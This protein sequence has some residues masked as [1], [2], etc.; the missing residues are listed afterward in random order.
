M[1]LLAVP[2]VA[3]VTLDAGIVR[4][5]A[6]TRA[7][8]AAD[9]VVLFGPIEFESQA[10][11][12]TQYYVETFPDPT[13]PESAVLTITADATV[14]LSA[15]TVRLNGDTLIVA[16][17]LQC[18][19]IVCLPNLLPEIFPPDSVLQAGVTYAARTGFIPLQALNTIEVE[20]D[21]SA[22]FTLTIAVHRPSTGQVTVYGPETFIRSGSPS[23]VADSFSVPAGL[24]PPHELQVDNG[25]P[26]GSAKA[27]SARLWL[28]GDEI[29]TGNDFSQQVD[30]LLRT[31]T[32]LPDNELEVRVVN[33]NG[34]QIT[35]RF[36][37][38]D[39]TPPVLTVTS[40][41][42]SA[43][44]ATDSVLVAGSVSDFTPVV[45]RANGHGAVVDTLGDWS[46]WIPLPTEGANPILVEATDL[47]GLSSSESLTVIRNTAPP[48]LVVSEPE[49]GL[50]TSS[51]SVTVA[52]T[53]T[54]VSVEVN[55][56]PLSL[57]GGA[58]SGEIAL[59]DGPNNLVIT[60]EAAGGAQTNEV[61]SVTRDTVPPMLTVTA[62]LD[63]SSTEDDSVAVAGTV[64]DATDVTVT[65]NGV[66]LPVAG[67]DSF[68]GN[69]A[70]EDGANTILVV[71]TDGAG[72]ESSDSRSVT[73][74]TEPVEPPPDPATVAPPIDPTVPTTVMAATEFLYT[75]PDPIQ[76][77]VEPGTIELKRATVVRG[78][79]L[80]QT[81]VALPGA[82]VSVKD[83]PEFGQTL[84][85]L[86]GGY[87][88]VVNGG[89]P[90]TV[91]YDLSGYL[92]A[93]RT[94]DV[95]WQDWLVLE[96]VALV[97]QDTA[98]TTIDFTDPIEVARG[99]PQTDA[100]GTRQATVLFPQGTTAQM[101]MA[102]GSTQ[103]LSTL[104][105]RL[106]EVTVGEIGPMT[107]PAR[108]PPTSGYT[109]AVNLQADEA[110]A[111]G[112]IGV[113]F[114]QPV[115]LYV[116]NFLGFPVGL[117]VPVGYYD[118]QA[119]AWMPEANGR[120]IEIVGVTGGLADIDTDG[121]GSANAQASLDSLGITANEQGELASLYSIG[122]TLWRMPLTHF[123]PFDGNWQR[124]SDGQTPDGK[125]RKGGGDPN[126]GGGDKGDGSD[127]NEDDP[128]CTRGSII[129]CENQVL[130]ER[131]PIVGT[132][133][134]LNYR[135][136]RVPGNRSNYRLGI[137]VTGDSVPDDLVKAIV[138]VTVAGRVFA[139][140][141]ETLTANEAMQFEWDGLDAY[142][143]PLSASPVSVT[144]SHFYRFY[145]A[146]PASTA[147]SFGLT[148][149][150]AQPGNYLADC[151]I[152]ATLNTE[153][154]QTERFDLDW[155]GYLGI[156]SWEAAGLGG[157]SLSAYHQYDPFSRT[158]YRGDGRQRT[159]SNVDAGVRTIAGNGK[160]GF[161]FGNCHG[162]VTNGGVA[163]EQALCTP[164]DVAVD[165]D[166]SFY[167]PH[168]SVVWK[169]DTA[170]IISRFAG[171]GGS[172]GYS[173]DGG[174]ATSA[175]MQN[176]RA[177]AL[178]PDGSLYIGD[179][180]NGV[181]RRVDPDGTISTFAGPGT[182]EFAEGLPATQTVVGSVTGIDV[183]ED[184]TVYL[185][186]TALGRVL[187]VDPEG[188]VYSIAGTGTPG[189]NGDSIPAHLAQVGSGVGGIGVGPDGAIY[190]ADRNNDR[191]RKIDL[192]GIITTVAGNGQGGSSLVDGVPATQS[193]VDGPTDVAFGPDGSLYITELFNDRLRRVT[194]DGIIT[195]VAGVAQ[196]CLAVVEGTP[197]TSSSLCQPNAVEVFNNEIYIVDWEGGRVRLLSPYA[198]G[199][200]TGDQRIASGDGSEAYVFG[201]LR[202]TETRSTLNG[203]LLNAFANDS[204]GRL[205]SLTNADGLVT[206]IERNG[207]GEPTAI[208]APFGQRTELTVDSL[209]WLSSITNP[210]GEVITVTHDSLGLLESM[211]DPR[212]FEYT[213]AYDSIGRLERDDDPA[214]GFQ[215][216]ARLETEGGHI[217]TR[218]TA[219]G[220]T[221]E[222]GTERLATSER[223][224]TVIGPDGHATSRSILRSGKT[225]MSLPDS[226]T[227]ETV[228]RPDPRFGMQA[229]QLDTL[230]VKTAAGK[231][232][233]VTTESH[234]TASDP[235][236]PLVLDARV[237]TLRLN[238]RVWEIAFDGTTREV[239][240]TS[241]MG[242][243]YTQQLDTLNRVTQ[244]SVPG[245]NDLDIAYDSAGFVSS[246]STGG[247]TWQYRYDGFGRLRAIEDP[248]ARADSFVF[249]AG[250]RLTRTILA[251]GDSVG[252]AYDSASNLTGLTPP[253][254]P[255]HTFSY[256]PVD[257]LGSYV[258]PGA[259]TTAYGNTLDRELGTVIRPGGD[260]IAVAYDTAGRPETL[261]FDGGQIGYSYEAQT[262]Q[263][264]G[265]SGPYGDGLSFG[266]DSFLL[267]DITWSGAVAGSYSVTYEDDFRVTEA[268]V[269]GVNP[270]SFGYDLDGL[271]TSA[272]TL[273]ID[274]DSAN[275]FVTGSTIGSVTTSQ[276][277]SG[278]G[279]LASFAAAYSGSGLFE[280][281]YA[282]DA[283]GR[284]DTLTQIIQ[285]DTTVFVYG[286]DE[287][288]RL[289]SV[290]TN[291]ALSATYTYD[292]NGNRLQVAG[293][294]GS[295]TGSYDDRDRLLSYG[296]ATYAYAPAGELAEKV[297]GSDTTRYAY[298]ALGNLTSIE[299]PNGTT[300][301]YEVDAAGRRIGRRVNGT[302]GQGFLY[303]DQ[304]SPVA[305][306]DGSGQVVSR[307]VYGDRINVPEY[308]IKGGTTYRI[309]A[310]HLGSVRLVVD[311]ATGAIAQRIYYDEFGVV[312]LNTNPSFQPFGFAGGITDEVTGF[313]R[314]GARDYDPDTGRWTTLD[315]LGIRGNDS[316]AYLYAYGNPVGH[317]DPTGEFVPLVV[318]IPTVGGLV[319]GF[320]TAAG[321][322]ARCGFS[323]GGTAKAFGRGF[324][325]GF[326]G[327]VVGLATTAFTEN[328]IAG[329][330]AAGWAADFVDQVLSGGPYDPRQGI[331]AGAVGGIAGGATHLWGPQ[332]K[333]GSF[334]P[335]LE[336][337][338]RLSEYGPNSRKLLA[339]EAAAGAVAGGGGFGIQAAG[340]GGCGC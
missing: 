314:F 145:Y 29:L 53:T 190:L 166:G 300:I 210:A 11:G 139:D 48:E 109:Y 62:P 103:P 194:P 309:V 94:V 282:R 235:E 293:P 267:T 320:F 176:V 137:P 16:D 250:N 232:L 98:V 326:A 93:D 51:D 212:G 30:T 155:H 121:D 175:K 37:S 39:T 99:T 25:A 313:V 105:V 312:T 304:L 27:S 325:A 1:A 303:R 66:P 233:V 33:P 120:I 257:L 172:P 24:G 101:R 340:G 221:W 43:V 206:T 19:G 240:V 228:L 5:S 211:K 324:A 141:F 144:I 226:T 113:E 142:G 165:A 302:L 234:V 77:G 35:V 266:Y 279:E 22:A 102:D 108:L 241:P 270:I 138:T 160:H 318:A 265:L 192:N 72:N 296:S 317:I 272:G 247:H 244:V 79:V 107:M 319:N 171:D 196:D 287:I 261:S 153:V 115:P 264:S 57:N 97:P 335:D 45:V 209:G 140:T 31:V 81:G 14:D 321:Q 88:M 328:P 308:M 132:D 125:P 276:G 195:T 263:L 82:T 133:L 54:G 2:I 3:S 91:E 295:V 95:A 110:E 185:Y 202:H 34:A 173:G 71:A 38:T 130:G 252:F 213:F 338:R 201:G 41:V 164:Y 106:T 197:G 260:T 193:I 87:D 28:N 136:G 298:D 17:T 60:A 256:T 126:M 85:R 9:S 188:I 147:E 227:I 249:D 333:P 292:A 238:G 245:L 114:D 224:R 297:A 150:P 92:S 246:A 307:F 46:V 310:D 306:L 58:F 127:N 207:A 15:L 225:T 218:T 59:A 305:E 179:G 26:D 253:G 156:P 47:G 174:P 237:D 117:A 290:E 84:S 248:Q 49:D 239:T 180:G 187:R 200:Q 322:V 289:K 254:R 131:I 299:L 159:A 52:G 86:D 268:R 294:G 13:P 336:K 339:N 161:I 277:Y 168:R 216:L 111:A 183:A 116:E 177:V 329:G 7:A 275:G 229:P 123:S 83:H 75:G 32:L 122:S 283:L 112:A 208:I 61:R 170:G 158:L 18:S 178:G 104:S 281:S 78:R 76:T 36:T 67:D 219:L 20:Y 74:T 217:V 278:F 330:A 334:M 128:E 230:R 215:T 255:E 143:R 167:I 90:L 21:G 274:R 96:D 100:D 269:N 4:G 301:S 146:V 189:Y 262:G 280:T 55:G 284:I 191:V 63:G 129:E 236:N 273:T 251:N 124:G 291:G 204:A 182:G 220:R 327:T 44:I 152:P 64:T 323:P 69:V 203:A 315:P 73:K 243:E 157:W 181:V 70:L 242:R 184:G 231:T 68:G 163:T 134:T 6:E 119:A 214:G 288:G 331:R 42:D 258:A 148:C 154:R 223:E 89:R 80:D 169:V 222:Y 205:E 135:S 337:W 149:R 56:S 285:G 10:T 199:L 198:G 162:T 186:A 8:A 286:Y 50:V 118:E 271:L 23:T 259:D 311:V 65:A 40:P 332:P 316:N 151:Q 12:A